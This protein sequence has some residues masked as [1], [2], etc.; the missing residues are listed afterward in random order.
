M[1]ERFKRFRHFSAS[2]ITSNSHD[3]Y[4]GNSA[5]GNGSHRVEG[6]NP[7]SSRRFPRP[8]CHLALAGQ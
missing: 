4:K 5:L 8:A 1:P 2:Q 6:N 3:D 7:I